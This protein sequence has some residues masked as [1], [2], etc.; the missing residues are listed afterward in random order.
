METISKLHTVFS[1]DGV[2]LPA[3]KESALGS[4]STQ[5]WS[6]DLD[7]AINQKFVADYKAKYGAY[8][9]FYAAQAYDSIL[10]IDHAVGKSGSTNT[11]KMRSVLAA[12]NIPTT[13]GSLKMNT[14]HFP[15]QNIYLREAVKDEDGLFTTKIISTVFVDHADSYAATCKF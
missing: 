1:V 2:T 4:V 7:N 15:I 6:P 9:S 14:N 3:L 5:T 8:P 10:A 13:R 11:A 12:G